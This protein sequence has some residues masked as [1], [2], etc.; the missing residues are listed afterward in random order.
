MLDYDGTCA[1]YR[2]VEVLWKLWVWV[3][4]HPPVTLGKFVGDA[5]ELSKCSSAGVCERER[6]RRMEGGREDRQTDRQT[7]RH[8]HTHT[9]T[10]PHILVSEEDLVF[11]SK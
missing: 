1:M 6:E 11:L 4:R 10:D 7:D 2:F 8:T 5:S 3:R 9:D